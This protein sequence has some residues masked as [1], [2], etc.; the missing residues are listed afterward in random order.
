MKLAVSTLG[1]H[2]F[3]KR[4]ERIIQTWRI[5]YPNVE[6]RLSRLGEQIIQTWI[7]NYPSVDNTPNVDS[8]L[9]Y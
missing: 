5:D 1:I 2:S 4:G 7:T 6:N 3:S 8:E 9:S